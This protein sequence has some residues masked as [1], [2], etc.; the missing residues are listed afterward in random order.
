MSEEKN[1]K[2]DKWFTAVP[3]KGAVLRNEKLGLELKLFKDDVL[4]IR[5]ERGVEY[6]AYR[7]TD[8]MVRGYIPKIDVI[9]LSKEEEDKLIFVDDSKRFGPPQSE[10]KK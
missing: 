5:G 8:I 6:M 10:Y 2:Q 1:W 4:S 3:K 7:V 9:K